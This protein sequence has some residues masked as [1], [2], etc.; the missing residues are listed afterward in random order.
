MS[1]RLH[2]TRLE[3]RC[4]PATWGN[5]WPDAAHLTLSFAP[6]GTAV[7]AVASTLSKLLAA[8]PTAD[9]QLAALR[10]FQTWAVNAN[11]NVSLL[12]DGGQ[13]FG[14]DGA[15][16]G[17]IRFGDVRLAA[18]PLHDATELARANP[19]DPLAGTWSGD[20]QLDNSMRYT[21]GGAG[22]YD[23]YTVL[24][25][26]FG[27]VLGLGDRDDPDVGHGRCLPGHPHGIIR[28]GQSPASKRSMARV[29]RTRMK[30]R[31]VTTAS[32]PQRG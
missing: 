7:G 27:H 14:T 10:A 12:A 1:R 22:G 11:I 26:E 13:P 2:V 32:P 9:W 4:T 18:I 20:V 16:Q 31:M 21:V 5:P 15:P 3:D 29:P 25:H 6:D 23:L 30:A 8:Y 17:D 19:F 24:L 28:R